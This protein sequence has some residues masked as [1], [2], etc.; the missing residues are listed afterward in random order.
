MPEVT[1]HPL[2]APSWTELSTTDETG[3]LSF[4]AA[5]FGWVDEP[6]D[7]GPDW[8]YQ[9]QKVNGQYACSIY[10]QS[11]EERSQNVPPHWNVYF[12]VSNA[13]ETVAAIGQNGGQVVFGPMGVF[14]AG[15]MAMC[16]DPQGSFFAIWQPKE[17]IGAGIKGETGAIVW[18]ELMTTDR[19]AATE[20]YRATL[21]LEQ[22]QVP[23][24]TMD[25]TMLK[26]GETEVAGVMQI[27]LDMGEFPPYW[28]VYFGVDNVDTSVEQA[29]RPPAA[30]PFWETRKARPSASSNPSPDTASQQGLLVATKDHLNKQRRRA[31]IS[32]A[33]LLFR[34]VGG[35]G[36]GAS[37]S[38]PTRLG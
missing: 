33:L 23:E 7:M 13:D 37:R 28:G 24:S 32:R 29:N 6:H 22:F 35:L 11:E 18:N 14:D 38:A 3:A 8:F 2:G 5:L 25:Y 19:A 26:A 4:Y 10:K 16:Q 20:F 36:R 15:R 30:L 9:M 34:R 31:R 12:N 17:H 21:G 27:T 1:S